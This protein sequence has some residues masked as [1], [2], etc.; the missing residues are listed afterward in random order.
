MVESIIYLN[1]YQHIIAVIV[2]VFTLL[3]MR[4]QMQ[5]MEKQRQDAFYNKQLNFISLFLQNKL[6]KLEKFKRGEKINN[7]VLLAFN[8]MLKWT[9]ERDFLEFQLL[10]PKA[11]LLFTRIFFYSQYI[12]D[13]YNIISKS[14][15]NSPYKRILQDKLIKSY[16]VLRFVSIRLEYLVISKI[17]N[18][19]DN[20]IE[21]MY[22]W[23]KNFYFYIFKFLPAKHKIDHLMKC[24]N[25]EKLN[26]KTNMLI[27][28][29]IINIVNNKEGTKNK[30][31]PK[32]IDANYI[33]KSNN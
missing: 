10:N 11:S 31:N 25:K 15:K 18:D 30:D 4:K 12:L 7:N 5:I 28:N 32:V 21:K 24:M 1:S 2:A 9:K 16:N 23:T 14:E 26:N 20:F 27:I 29:Q 3:W 33:D 13:Q 8:F 22:T 6:I 19:D 17:F